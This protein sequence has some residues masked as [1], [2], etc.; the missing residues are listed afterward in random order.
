MELSVT[1][2]GEVS[3]VHFNGDLDG[4][5]SPEAQA[6]MAELISQGTSKILVDFENL[7]FVS[8]AGLRVLLWTA[9]QVQKL[10]GEV[11]ICSPNAL[12]LEVIEVSGFNTIVKVTPTEAEALQ[13]F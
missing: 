2:S 8:S 11:R 13:N 9:K 10:K 3:I 4:Q 12:V 5:S 6:M 7:G 1:Q